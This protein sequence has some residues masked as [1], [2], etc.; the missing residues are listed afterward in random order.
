MR[1]N[2]SISYETTTPGGQN[3]WGEQIPA[4]TGWSDPID[5]SIKANN[6]NRKGR[7]ED[8]VFRQASYVVLIE[9]RELPTGIKRLRLTRYTEDLG[10]HD[11][12][13]IVPLLTVGRIQI[14]V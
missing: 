13:N 14:L 10:E 1:K 12:L 5:C 9:A 6:D 8:G 7:Y 11:V 4:Q 3:E 2:G